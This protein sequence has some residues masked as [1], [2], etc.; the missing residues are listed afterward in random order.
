MGKKG[1]TDWWMWTVFLNADEKE[2]LDDVQYVIYNLGRTFTPPIAKVMDRE[3]GFSLTRE[4]SK[5]FTIS[6]RVEFKSK[7]DPI[8]LEHELKFGESLRKAIYYIFLSTEDDI[9]INNES[10]KGGQ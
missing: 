6:A 5:T 10:K 2:E 9:I 3:S 4:G 7:K 1:Q 8:I